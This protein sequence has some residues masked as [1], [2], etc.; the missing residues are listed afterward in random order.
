MS[1]I[2]IIV[3]AFHLNTVDINEINNY[4]CSQF[5]ISPENFQ[6][7]EFENNKYKDKINYGI[8][9]KE[10]NLSLQTI[11]QLIY[12]RNC[13]QNLS[14]KVFE[15]LQLNSKK[16]NDLEYLINSRKDLM[17]NLEKKFY[18]KNLD[19]EE[20]KNNNILDALKDNE[21]RKIE[22][23]EKAINK[24]KIE[25]KNMVD[26]LDLLNKKINNKKYIQKDIISKKVELDLKEENENYRDKGLF[27]TECI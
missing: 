25:F 3:P 15:S 11:E 27:F 6:L 16:I 1:Y 10:S 14:E 18:Q 5:N 23:S 20:E 26:E 19:K 21:K 24:I 17:H 12:E 8:I 4:C 7:V 13:I 9:F 22:Y 2:S